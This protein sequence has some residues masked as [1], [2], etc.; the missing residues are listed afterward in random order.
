MTGNEVREKY[1]KFFEKRGHKIISPVPL[2]LKDDPT[3]LFTSAG[4]QPLVSYLM[5]QTY[6]GNLKRLVD[7]QPC[8]RAQDIEDVGDD[9]HDTLFEMLGNWS[10]GDYFKKDQIPWEWEFFTKELGLT[11]ERLYVTIFEGDEQVSIDTE[12]FELWKSL[13]VS[14]DHIYKY[15]VKK[16]WWSRAGTPDQMPVGEIGGPSSEVFYEF[17][18][19]EHDK[20]FGEKCHPN[21]DCGRFIEIGN[22][23]F[24]QYKKTLDGL[25]RL[26]NQNVDFGGGLER[27]L[28]AVNNTSDM[29]ENDLHSPIIKTVCEQLNI[30]Y[31][32]DKKSLQIIADHVKA[33]IFIIVGGVTPG[34]KLQGYLLRRLIRRMLVKIYFLKGEAEQEFDFEKLIKSV[35]DIYDGVYLDYKIHGELVKKIIIEE[36]GKFNKN[37]KNGINKLTKTDAKDIDEKFAFDLMQSEGFPFEITAELAKEKGIEID[38]NKFDEMLRE[39]Q[40][41]SRNSSKDKFKIK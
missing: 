17:T 20:K 12:A 18:D 3:T 37:L 21:C 23:V 13:G 27:M 2:V 29:F 15:G 6:P 7:S 40:D 16:N 35:F 10:L 30:K 31:E 33:A 14:E 41:L 4:M 32:D 26:P 19:I 36:A 39:H 11:K 28:M 1:L 24:M 22:S 9:R 8:F 38:K 5:G 34:N 25:E